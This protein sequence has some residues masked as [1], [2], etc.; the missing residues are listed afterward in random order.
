MNTEFNIEEIYLKCISKE[1]YANLDGGASRTEFISFF[2]TVYGLGL[3]FVFLSNNYNFPEW[4]NFIYGIWFV[5]NT[6][7]LLCVALRRMVDAGITRWWGLLLLAFPINLI[8][9]LAFKPSRLISTSE[10]NQAIAFLKQ[11]NNEYRNG[12]FNEAIE[13]YD[14]AIEINKT[15]KEAYKNREKAVK[16]L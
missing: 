10:R 6:I 12:K 1:N 4:T 8:L 5:F 3:G 15:F 9:I 2:C 7:P 13:C 14:K 11:G 16:K